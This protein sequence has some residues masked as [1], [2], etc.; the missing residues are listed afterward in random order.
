LTDSL[1]GCESWILADDVN[2]ESNP[3][4][5]ENVGVDSLTGCE[6]RESSRKELFP[7]R[8]VKFLVLEGLT[9]YDI[10]G[11]AP[12]LLLPEY[13]PDEGPLHS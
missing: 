2:V 3:M 8:R 4:A 10:W 11:V 7:K 1:T 13:H 9:T 5:D 12:R 6:S